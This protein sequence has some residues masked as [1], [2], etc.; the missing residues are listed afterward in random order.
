MLKILI[1]RVALSALMALP[2]MGFAQKMEDYTITIYA[3]GA[4][5]KSVVNLWHQANGK[6]QSDT[7]SIQNGVFKLK[8]QV[9]GFTSAYITMLDGKVGP[10][11]GTRPDGIQFY[12]EPG[13]IVFSTPDSLYKA[14]ITGTKANNDQVEL[15]KLLDETETQIKKLEVQ[16]RDAN[17]KG[18]QNKADEI[19]ANFM[20]LSQKQADIKGVYFDAHLSSPVSLNILRTLADPAQ[21]FEN[22]TKYFNMLSDDLKN[23]QEGKQYAASLNAAKAIN[24]NSIAPNFTS[25]DTLDKEISL[26][27]FRGK[28]VLL[29][30]WASWCGHCRKENPNVVKAYNQFKNKNFTVLG[31]SLDGGNDAKQ[32]WMDAIKKDGLLW[33]Q[34]S[35]LGGWETPIVQKYMITS[36]PTNFLIDPQGKIIAK[37]LRG[38]ELVSKLNSLLTK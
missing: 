34:L 22:A 12:L 33:T 5:P 18:D 32:K 10:A 6:V 3:K 8:G 9:A 36:I 2:V 11:Q 31:V 16:Y 14:V 29:D 38:E 1:K 24:V 19:R 28:Y 21:D 35:D 37:N 20:N 13:N 4:K 7:A 26:S 15:N 17:A 25:K 23:S 27:D 30:F